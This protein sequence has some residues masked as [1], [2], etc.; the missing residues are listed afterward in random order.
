MQLVAYPCNHAVSLA[1]SQMR[2]SLR[3]AVEAPPLCDGR[4]SSLVVNLAPSR[5]G[6]QEAADVCL[7]GHWSFV[8][9]LPK[10]CSPGALSRPRPAPGLCGALLT[11]LLAQVFDRPGAG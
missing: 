5:Q 4:E 7:G 2:P 9:W 8:D 1:L 3:R 10:I 6:D 11:A